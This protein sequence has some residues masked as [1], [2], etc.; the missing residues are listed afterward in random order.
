MDTGTGSRPHI[1]GSPPNPIEQE[2]SAKP[3]LKTGVAGFGHKNL[4]SMQTAPFHFKGSG[5]SIIKFG[6]LSQ[7][8][9]DQFSSFQSCLQTAAETS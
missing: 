2:E 5:L 8:T 4:H 1:G 3:F 7:S 9:Y 6:E